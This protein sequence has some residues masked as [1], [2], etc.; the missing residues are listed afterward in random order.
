MLKNGVKEHFEAITL[1]LVHD[2]TSESPNVKRV[3]A[4]VSLETA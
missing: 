4:Y 2:K 3:H 1:G